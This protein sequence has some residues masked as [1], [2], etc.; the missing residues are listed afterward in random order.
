[1]KIVL[2]VLVGALVMFVLLKIA[3]KTGATPSD[4]GERF[5]EL[6]KTQQAKNLIMTNEFR[7]LVKTKEFINLA[8]SLAEDQ[9]KTLA[10]T[11]TYQ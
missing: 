1:M 5:K 11:L 6:A 3:A 7:E 10:T 8:R 9:L 4:T 2:W